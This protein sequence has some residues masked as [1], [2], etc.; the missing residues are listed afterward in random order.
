MNLGCERLEDLDVMDASFRCVTCVYMVFDMFCRM[1]KFAKTHMKP[2][3][4]TCVPSGKSFFQFMVDNMCAISRCPPSVKILGGTF[5]GR[6]WTCV[7]EKVVGGKVGGTRASR[8]R[9][10]VV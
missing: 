6:G 7:R 5:R 3:G 9:I 1:W 8:C 10:F 4:G 2:V